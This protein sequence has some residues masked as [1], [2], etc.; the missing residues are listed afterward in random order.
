MLN[1]ANSDDLESNRLPRDEIEKNVRR[2]FDDASAVIDLSPRHST[3]TMVLRARIMRFS[4]VRLLNSLKVDGIEREANAALE[5]TKIVLSDPDADENAK[6]L[7]SQSAA[8]IS[9]VSSSYEM[10]HVSTIRPSFVTHADL[11]QVEGLNV[12][13]PNGGKKH[14]IARTYMN[15][16]GPVGMTDGTP[17][18]LPPGVTSINDIAHLA[19]TQLVQ[20][21]GE[22]GGGFF[23]E[24]VFWMRHNGILL[25][26]HKWEADG[27]LDT[28]TATMSELW[29]MR[30]CMATHNDAK[31]FHREML[32]ASK[33]GGNNGYLDG[34][35]IFSPKANEKSELESCIEDLVVSCTHPKKRPGLRNQQG[36]M[37]MA[38]NPTPYLQ[39]FNGVFVVDRVVVKVYVI[40][41]FNPTQGKLQRSCLFGANGL[42]NAAA[43]AVMEWLKGQRKESDTDAAASPGPSGSAT[44]NFPKWG[45]L[46]RC[47]RC[48]VARGDLKQCSRCKKVAYCTKECQVKHYKNGH[49]GPCRKEAGN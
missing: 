37:M 45:D 27:H 38:A 46:S 10:N 6:S 9:D 14:F 40:E 28:D 21:Y 2:Q 11:C 31:N 4:A 13:K 35:N 30:W 19:P 5:D 33:L 32:E 49:K 36:R 42:L 44:Q 15:K 7:A 29:D 43:R 26:K 20:S 24:S 34:F 48:G 18:R 3:P 8:C 16:A 17:K 25:G 23:G 12:G 47:A 22:H 1:I 41:G 39:Q